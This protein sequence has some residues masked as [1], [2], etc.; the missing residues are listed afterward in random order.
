LDDPT[1]P[2]PIMERAKAPTPDRSAGRADAVSGNDRD[3]KGGDIR[4]SGR[5]R[6][7]AGR[8]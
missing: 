6:M 2:D 7:L 4:G 5:K 3:P 1:S 8:A